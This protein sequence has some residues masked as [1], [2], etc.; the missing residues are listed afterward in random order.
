MA[1][2]QRIGPYLVERRLATGGMAEVFIASR[3]GSRGFK[4]RVALK[5][6]LP[7]FASDPEFV[8]LFVAEA[9]LAVRV[10]HPH[11][12]QVF[13]FGEADGAL[14]LAMELV[15]GTTVHRLLNAAAAQGRV[16]LDVALHIVSQ[17]AEALDFA[18]N[19]RAENG[20]SLHIVHRDVSP[21]NIL[22]TRTGHV[23]LT[24]FGIA[25]AA[26]RLPQTRSGQVRGKLGYMS[27]EQV[28]GQRVDSR[29]DV[30][31]LATVFAELLL[32][33]PLFRGN[34]DIEILLQIRD[35]N[36]QALTSTDRQIP[37]DVRELLIAALARQ[38]RDRLSAG[39]FAHRCAEIMRQRGMAHGPAR[40]AALI[41]RLPISPVS[42]SDPDHVKGDTNLFDT[43]EMDLRTE[44]NAVRPVLTSPE[45]YRVLDANG[46]ILGPF[47]FPKLVELVTSGQIDA[48]TRVSKDED[49]FA[50]ITRLPEFTRF[51]TSPALQWQLEELDHA[52]QRG[53]LGVTRLLPLFFQTFVT[54]RTGVLHLFDGQRR[55][56]IYFVD[57]KPEYVA[58]TESRELLGEYLVSN[59]HCL[60]M[61]VEMA[62]ALL[63]RYGGRIGDALV[64]LGVLRPVEL[65][66]VIAS[67]VRWRLLEAFRWRAGEW[68]FVPELR[69]HEET[70][71][72]GIDSLELLRDAV[73]AADVRELFAALLPFEERVLVSNLSPSVPS[74]AFSL[75]AAWEA[76][77]DSVRG[78]A[79]PQMLIERHAA[80]GG[81]ADDAYRAL[82]L[83]LSCELLGPAGR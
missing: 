3:E 82:F 60:R 81:D 66:R 18:H 19:L 48:R 36:L 9:Q 5:R 69:S 63:P 42:S 26:L 32:L 46:N 7:Q 35:V 20:E 72:L 16:P 68:A 49:G 10:T 43:S 71:P 21:A 12:V 50:A 31:T 11:V 38:P 65:F 41:E 51:V 56:K 55:K 74:L 4:K 13:D 23:K 62:L 61:E 14:F 30:F 6:I 64:G 76:V 28:V 1:T 39:A 22:L 44:L 45:I 2:P 25:T 70:F 59:G 54:R 27:P 24:D 29:S 83:G 75:P 15:E 67:Q 57:G 79:T 52:D 58:S 47:S 40:L 73:A 33:Q 8:E 53:P 80:S 37:K 77:L 17:T 34:S 78:D